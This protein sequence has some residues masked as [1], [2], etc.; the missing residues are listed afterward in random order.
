[1]STKTYN[2]GHINSKYIFAILIDFWIVF[3]I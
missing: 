1:L 3:I 2:Y